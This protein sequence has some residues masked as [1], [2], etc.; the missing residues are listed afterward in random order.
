MIDQITNNFYFMKLEYI[1]MVVII[2][3]AVMNNL[4]NKSKIKIKEYIKGIDI[5]IL[6]K[7]MFL[8]F[9]IVTTVQLVFISNNKQEILNSFNILEI[10]AQFITNCIFAPIFEEII[11]RFGIYK[12][13]NKKINIFIS[14]IITSILFSLL[15]LYEIE[16]FIILLGISIVWNYVFYK[17]NN[18]V[19]PILL[20]FIHNLY[21]LA[22]DFFNYNNYLY[23]LLLLNIIGF[24]IITKKQKN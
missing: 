17:S 3:F 9:I 8:S 23:I 7:Y 5:Y 4:N 10:L 1:V 22:I 14:I 21:A 18:L 15:H 19:Y 13:L 6:F 12:K 2:G 24:I 20:H 11:F 16:G